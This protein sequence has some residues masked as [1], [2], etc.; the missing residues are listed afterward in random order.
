M[1]IVTV[2]RRVGSRADTRRRALL[3][4]YLLDKKPILRQDVRCIHTP[5]ISGCY[6]RMFDN[7]YINCLRLLHIRQ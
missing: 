1:S 2:P 7:F 3:G 6:S 4:P 5:Y